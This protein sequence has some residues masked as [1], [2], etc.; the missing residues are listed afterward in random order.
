MKKTLTVLAS[1]ATLAIGSLVVSSGAEARNFVRHHRAP[2]YYSYSY[3]GPA[4][5]A[6]R[7]YNYNYE[8]PTYAPDRSPSR[9]E[10]PGRPDFQD[11][12]RG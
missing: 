6:S 2:A 12:S 8:T 1:A 3:Q 10:N 11:G 4:Y 9:Y 7:G 5:R